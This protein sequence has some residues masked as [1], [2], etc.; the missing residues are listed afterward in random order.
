MQAIHSFYSAGVATRMSPPPPLPAP[1]ATGAVHA[2]AV[3][4]ASGATRP[5]VDIPQ[6]SGAAAGVANPYPPQP[7]S[8]FQHI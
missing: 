5:R 1:R 3:P 2:A 4:T 7:L 8:I 6:A